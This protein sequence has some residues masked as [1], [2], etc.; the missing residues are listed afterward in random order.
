M[1]SPCK[2]VLQYKLNK[3]KESFLGSKLLET[4]TPEKKLEKKQQNDNQILNNLINGS[5]ELLAVILFVLVV[6][7]VVNSIKKHK[8][9][10]TTMHYVKNI[11]LTL[12]ERIFNIIKMKTFITFPYLESSLSDMEQVESIDMLQY[13]PIEQLYYFNDMT[14]KILSCFVCFIQIVGLILKT[15][16]LNY[17]IMIDLLWLMFTITSISHKTMKLDPVYKSCFNVSEIKN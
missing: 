13:F 17:S 11:I 1:C 15:S 5:S 14:Q 7:D 3:E 10:L 8:S 6:I 4:R 2:R 9:L 16:K 12:F